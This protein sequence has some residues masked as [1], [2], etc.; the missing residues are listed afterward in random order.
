MTKAGAV[1]IG[2]VGAILMI[3]AKLSTDYGTDLPVTDALFVAGEVGLVTGFAVWAISPVP[4]LRI[5]VWRAAI[6]ARIWSLG[7]WTLVVLCVALAAITLRQ[8]QLDLQEQNAE[9]AERQRIGQL[10]GSA[11]F[12]SC[13]ASR[14][15]QHAEQELAG[16]T[17]TGPFDAYRYGAPA[18]DRNI[19]METY[20][21]ATADRQIC[22]S[23]AQSRKIP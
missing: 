12:R 7:L 21:R 2:W 5:K 11:T 16:K 8:M 3:V 20:V 10:E 4:L 1:R 22:L 23:E 9:Q 13:M 19:V 18:P 14:I 17:K 15:R 6:P